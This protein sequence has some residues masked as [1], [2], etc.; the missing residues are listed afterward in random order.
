MRPH[1]YYASPGFERAGLR[2][3]EM[4]WILERV[5]DPATLFVPVW[6]NQDLVVEIEG[7]E[8][9]AVANGWSGIGPVLG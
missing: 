1:N 6:R 3:R 4:S 7:G 9:R 8:M 5:A 2:R